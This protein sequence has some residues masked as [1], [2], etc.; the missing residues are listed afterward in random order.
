MLINLHFLSLSTFPGHLHPSEG[1]GQHRGMVVLMR[2]LEASWSFIKVLRDPGTCGVRLFW[3]ICLPL[4]FNHSGLVWVPGRGV[5]G[6]KHALSGVTQDE[7]L[8]SHACTKVCE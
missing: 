5:G 7:C 1:D 4:N 8:S 6:Y 3:R 2:L